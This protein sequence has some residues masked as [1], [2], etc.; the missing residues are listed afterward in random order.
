MSILDR[1]RADMQT[2]TS[3]PND[4][5][6]SAVFTA[7]TSE[8]ATVNVLHTKHKTAYTDDGEMVNIQIA[9]I[10]VAE[11]LLTAVSY[12]TRDAENEVYFQDHTVT[13]ADSSGTVR[14]YIVDQWFPDETL[15]LIV[16]ILKQYN[17]S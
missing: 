15:G 8:T 6:T 4:W 11:A 16:L 9:S 1:A 2:I 12:P 14:N 3:N 13:C 7:P 10:A 5:G 17:P